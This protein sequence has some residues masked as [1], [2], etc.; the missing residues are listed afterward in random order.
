MSQ[1]IYSSVPAWAHPGAAGRE[2]SAFAE[3]AESDG[4]TY[5]FVVVGGAAADAGGP[6]LTIP[7]HVSSRLITGTDTDGVLAQLCDALDESVV[8]VRVVLIGPVGACLRLRAAAVNAGVEDDEITVM[9]RG[10][11]PVDVFC[12][13]CRCITPA[14]AAADDI[15]KCAGCERNLV[16]YYHVSRRMGSYLGFMVDAEVLRP[17]TNKTHADQ[18]GTG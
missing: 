12:A 10:S 15:V 18:I 8:G 6:A 5:L 11:G 17:D 4:V 13:H 14:V 2:P 16:V 7:G 9:P 3:L 1:I